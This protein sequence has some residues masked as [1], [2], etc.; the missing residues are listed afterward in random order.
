MRFKLGQKILDALR[1][2]TVAEAEMGVQAGG[3][4]EIAR[5]SQPPIKRAKA[6]TGK[7]GSQLS[8]GLLNGSAANGTANG[9]AGADDKP[10]FAPG[11][12]PSARTAGLV[13]LLTGG[14]SRCFAH[15]R[16]RKSEAAIHYGW[17]PNLAGILGHP[18]ISDAFFLSHVY[19]LAS[20]ASSVLLPSSRV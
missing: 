11:T 15:A 19:L 5:E 17:V 9:V 13:S 10:A 18:G 12:D 14:L 20:Q 1:Q 6:A 3:S 7:A 8:A 16:C 4:I 2:G